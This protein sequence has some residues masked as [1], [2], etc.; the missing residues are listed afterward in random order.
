MSHF[1]QIDETN[2]VVNV[3]VVEQDFINTGALGDPSKWIQTSYNTRGNVHYAPNSHTPDDG[4]ALRGNY[5]GIGYKYDPTNDVFYAPQP[6]PSWILDTTTWLWK[7]PVDY[8]NDIGTGSPPKAYR[9]D[10]ATT[11]WV[12]V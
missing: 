1:A 8:P 2:T 12:Q 11:S 10:E 4:I 5:A 3:L 6:F 7:A 9:W